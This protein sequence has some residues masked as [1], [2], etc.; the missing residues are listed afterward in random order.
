MAS[1]LARAGTTRADFLAAFPAMQGWLCALEASH[2]PCERLACIN[3][4]DGR[5][6]RTVCCP[7]AW[8]VSV[9]KGS[10]ETTFVLTPAAMEALVALY[11]MLRD[12]AQER[13]AMLLAAVGE[14]ETGPMSE[15]KG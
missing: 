2:G 14:N 15:A 1:G 9:S 7:Q 10:A 11:E 8:I 4:T 12:P 5:S 6:V 3:L 13:W